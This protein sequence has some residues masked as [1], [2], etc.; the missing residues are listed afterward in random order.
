MQVV[1]NKIW[2][3]LD[4]NTMITATSNNPLSIVPQI[5][6]TVTIHDKSWKIVAVDYNY[7]KGEINVCSDKF[8]A[9]MKSAKRVK[10]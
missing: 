8:V 6:A 10:S 9:Y 3:C 5:G 1:W 7:D 2:F 4:E